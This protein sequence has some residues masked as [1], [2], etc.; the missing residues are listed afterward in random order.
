MC[1]AG[2][3][4]TH[5]PRQVCVNKSWHKTR[6]PRDICRWFRPWRVQ[7]LC[8][9]HFEVA[10]NELF[11]RGDQ[12]RHAGQLLRHWPY[13]LLR[14]KYTVRILFNMSIS[15]SP[16]ICS[17]LLSLFPY[18][19]QTPILCYL[20]VCFNTLRYVSTYSLNLVVVP[21]T[22]SSVLPLGTLQ[23]TWAFVSTRWVLPL[24]FTGY[25]PRP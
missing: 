2:W 13:R 4:T 17:N 12:Y 11:I 16:F 20:D 25:G 18:Y 10:Q 21:L 9:R 15:P 22:L 1:S 6:P 23:Y 8:S 24:N 5:R 7:G 19:I 3:G 14:V